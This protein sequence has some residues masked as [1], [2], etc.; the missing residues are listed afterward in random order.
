MLAGARGEHGRAHRV[1]VLRRHEDHPLVQVRPRGRG[2]QHRLDGQPQRVGQRV[3]HPGRRRVGVGVRGEQR[4]RRNGSAGA[5]AH[6]W[7]CRPRRCRRRAA[8][9]GDARAAGRRRAP[10]R[11]R[12]GGVDRDRHGAQRRR[13]GRRRPDRP[14]PTTAASRRRVRRVQHV[15]DVG[16][17]NAHRASTLSAIASTST[18]HSGRTAARRYSPSSPTN[19]SQRRTAIPLACR[20][21][22][23]QLGVRRR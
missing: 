21:L 13:R 20:L 5:P 8:A 2:R 12:G 6:P 4:T 16:Q 17:P 7:R 1:G 18:G 3:G 22:S 23:H 9:A 10:R 14:S 11:P 15:D 19:V